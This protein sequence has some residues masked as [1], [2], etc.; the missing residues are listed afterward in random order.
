MTDDEHEALALTAKLN[1]ALHR[2]IGDG[3]SAAGDRTEVVLH[4]HALQ[5]MVHAQAGARAYPDRYRPLGHSL[6][7]TE[8]AAQRVAMSAATIVAAKARVAHLGFTTQP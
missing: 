5:N 1:G 2:I 7:P 8:A 4:V 3:P 6:R